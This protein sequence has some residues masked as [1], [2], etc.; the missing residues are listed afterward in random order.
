MKRFVF[1]FI[2]VASPTFV[3]SQYSYRE[4]LHLPWGSG[5]FAVGIR[6]APDGQYGPMSFA[7]KNDTILVL[8]SQNTQLKI[9]YKDS[10]LQKIGVPSQNVDDF[11]WKNSEHYFLLSDNALLEFTNQKL[12]QAYHPDSPRDLITS[13]KMDLKT[14]TIY[15]I[16]NESNSTQAIKGKRLKRIKAHAIADGHGQFVSVTKKDWQTIVVNQDNEIS[17]EITSP[18]RDLAAVKFLGSTPGG[19]LYIYLEKLSEQDPLQVNR[20]IRL[21][22]K[23]GS[24]KAR[25]IIPTHAHS[26]IFKE[27]YVDGEGNL[28]HMISAEDGIHVIGWYLTGEY[29]K[30]SCTYSYPDKFSKFYHYNLREEREPQLRKSSSQ[31][32]KI[33]TE[34]PLSF[35]PITRDEAL[36]F[37]DTYVLHQWT[38]TEDNLTNGRILDPQGVEVETPS[39]VRV[40]AN[41]KIPYQ[42]GGFSRLSDFDL[43]LSVGKYAGDIA[44]TGVSSYCVGVDCSGFVSRCWKLPDHYST[45]MM[46]DYITVAYDSWDQLQPADAVHKPGHV[47]MFVA[48]NP[49]GSLLTLEA[50]GRDWR[51]SYRPYYLSQLNGYKPRYYIYMEDMPGSV[52]KPE[53]ASITVADSVQINWQIDNTEPLTGFRVYANEAGENWTTLLN[54]RILS[55]DKTSVKFESVENT[56]LFYKVT[57]VTSSEDHTESFPTDAYGYFNANRSEKILIVDGFDRT[58]GSYPFAYHTFAMTMG[59]ALSHFNISFETA[60]NEV[61][62]DGKIDLENY[63]AVI[64]LLGDESTDEETFDPTEQGLVTAYLRQGGKLFVTGSEVAWDL[65]HKGNA[66]DKSFI[67]NFLKTAYNYDD[68]GSYTVIGSKNTIFEGL[69]LHYDDGTK[70]IYEEDWPDAFQTVNGS[71]AALKYANGLIA[72]TAFEGLVPGGAEPAQILLM[73]FPFETIYTQSERIDLMQKV[74]SFFEL[75]STMVAHHPIQKPSEFILYGN[76]PNPFNPGTLIRYQ[77]ASEEKVDLRIFNLLGEE[78]RS[79]VNEHKPAG[80]YEIYWDGR[81][82][83]GQR[84]ASGVYV[85]QMKAG[86]T[87]KSRKMMLLR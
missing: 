48:F 66:T 10:L 60:A 33:E 28:F 26:F 42:W 74:L 56:P 11:G 22:D 7:V 3:F 19:N 86:A 4:I 5:D 8:D 44:T 40:G 15:A 75:S 36:A 37:G 83:R 39:W 49:N 38:A 30:D 57:G 69:V 32:K 18:R 24:M 34:I 35:P 31:K 27:F 46:D 63:T 54:E 55:P 45:R 72:A 84:V 68:S 81:D 20:E 64:W 9:F 51:V 52:P 61:I 78:I 62:I 43:G 59:M 23:N 71:F 70:G 21:Y 6:Q 76:Y 58:D 87:L 47:R 16:L 65:D 80:D 29:F 2:L 25:F 73:G 77:L 13:V 1:I 17:F 41:M 12:I 67:K 50:S 14:G 82:Q 79:L 53:L 85:Y